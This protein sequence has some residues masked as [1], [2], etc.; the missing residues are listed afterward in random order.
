MN[1]AL[2]DRVN[3]FDS[4]WRSCTGLQET[5]VSCGRVMPDGKSVSCDDAAHAAP[6]FAER[7]YVDWSKC[8]AFCFVAE[9]LLKRGGEPLQLGGRALDILITLVERAGEVVATARC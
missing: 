4:G 9:R 5:S 2:A 8:D 1:S 3:G 7:R 6:I